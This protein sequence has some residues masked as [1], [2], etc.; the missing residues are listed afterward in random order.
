MTAASERYVVVGQITGLF[1]VQGWLKVH[2]YTR[3]REDILAYDH[4]FLRRGDRWERCAVRDG[5]LQGP[6]VVVQIEGVDDR[7]V[8]R[9]FIGSDIA[10]ESAQLAP[11]PEGEYYWSQLEGLRVVTVDGVELGRVSHLIET[12]ANDVVVVRGER[13]RLLP[14]TDDVVRSVD[15]AAGVMTVDWDPEF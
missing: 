14:Y 1:G 13:E 7:E 10:I 9:G 15:L 11:L 6:G 5:R 4:W 8:A 3:H 12:G 2:A